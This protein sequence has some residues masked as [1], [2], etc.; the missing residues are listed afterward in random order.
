M[1]PG[2]RGY[3]Q[4]CID[5]ADA[6]YEPANPRALPTLLDAVQSLGLPLP[7]SHDDLLKTIDAIEAAGIITNVSDS[8]T[9]WRT[10]GACGR[11]G[12]AGYKPDGNHELAF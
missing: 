12:C 11:R 9:A 8:F 7:V 10:P 1:V 2:P 4:E 6:G 5:E 3:C